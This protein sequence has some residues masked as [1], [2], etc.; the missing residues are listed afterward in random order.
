MTRRQD[1]TVAVGPVRRLRIKAQ[2][3]FKQHGGDVSHAHGHAGVAGICG[4]DGV[5]REGADRGG[6]HPM[7]GVGFAEGLDVHVTGVLWAAMCGF[8]QGHN[9]ADPKIK[10]GLR[11]A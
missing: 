8:A 1:K 11:D 9:R 6:A 2:V 10:A 3:L 7:L 4:S 5:K